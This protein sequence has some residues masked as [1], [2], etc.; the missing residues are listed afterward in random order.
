MSD[1]PKAKKLREEASAAG[2]IHQVAPPVVRMKVYKE[3]E[4]IPIKRVTCYN[5][6][7]A[8]LQF[9]IGNGSILLAEDSGFTQ[10]GMVVGTGPGLAGPNGQRVPSQLK[11]GDVVAFYGNPTTVLNPKTGIYADQRVILI[12]ER[13]IICG[14]EAKPFTV[15]EAPKE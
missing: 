12:P 15:V 3:G 7:V 1:I 14:L 4:S 13:A 9:R 10:E 2:Q 5:E 11:M 6:F 8:L